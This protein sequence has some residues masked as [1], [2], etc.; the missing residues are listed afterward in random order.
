MF[1]FFCANKKKRLAI[2]N[3]EHVGDLEI[4]FFSSIDSFK[5]SEID[6][7][8]VNESELCKFRFIIHF[9]SNASFNPSV[10]DKLS[11]NY[12]DSHTKSLTCEY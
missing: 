7:N 1:N 2:K 9:S 6:A 3:I 10:I 8:E 12:N 4:D 5:M 11:F